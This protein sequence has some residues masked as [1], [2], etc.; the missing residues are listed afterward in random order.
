[1]SV[2]KRGDVIHAKHFMIS[3]YPQH[4]SGWGYFFY[5]H[6]DSVFQQLPLHLSLYLSS[7]VRFTLL[8]TQLYIYMWY[9]LIWNFVSSGPW[10]DVQITD[11]ACITGSL[12]CKN[13]QHNLQNIVQKN[14]TAGQIVPL[15]MI[16]L[17]SDSYWKTWMCN[18]KT[19]WSPVWWEPALNVFKDYCSFCAFKGNLTDL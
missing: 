6:S 7:Q 4:L 9:T 11:R 12:R 10:C 15:F 16:N 3:P 8:P 2:K 5:A 17:Y 13:G 19:Q 14:L 18:I 1:M